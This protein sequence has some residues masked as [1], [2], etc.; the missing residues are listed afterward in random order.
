MRSWPCT[1]AHT[2][3]PEGGRGS[4]VSV[5]QDSAVSKQNK[6]KTNETG[7]IN[8][9]WGG[10]LLR[11]LA[12]SLLPFSDPFLLTQLRMHHFQTAFYSISGTLSRRKSLPR[13]TEDYPMYIHHSWSPRHSLVSKMLSSLCYRWETEAPGAD[14]PMSLILLISDAAGTHPQ[15]CLLTK[16]RVFHPPTHSPRQNTELN[17]KGLGSKRN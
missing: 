17:M 10:A 14:V 9:R 8:K 3:N 2:F 6:R 1:G 5:F 16:H 7:E 4:W 11:H 12:G 13:C 15:M